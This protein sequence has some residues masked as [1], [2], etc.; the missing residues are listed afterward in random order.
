MI[1]DIFDVI[2]YKMNSRQIRRSANPKGYMLSTRTTLNVVKIQ[3]ANVF[4]PPVLAY[5]IKMPSTGPVV[6]SE[7]CANHVV[8]TSIARWKNPFDIGHLFPE[9][10]KKCRGPDFA[11]L[12]GLWT[13]SWPSG[14]A[15]RATNIFRPRGRQGQAVSAVSANGRTQWRKITFFQNLTQQLSAKSFRRLYSCWSLV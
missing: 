12:D 8:F 13:R 9:I 11:A 1:L 7:V 15:D 6:R 14:A 5:R 4:K 2:R 10:P 3:S